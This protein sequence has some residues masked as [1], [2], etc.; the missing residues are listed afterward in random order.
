MGLA[1]QLAK[2]SDQLQIALEGIL[3][4]ALILVPILWPFFRE[5]AFFGGER[6]VAEE[7]LKRQIEALEAKED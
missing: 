3:M 2:D 4:V 6:R 5:S 1:E 7:A